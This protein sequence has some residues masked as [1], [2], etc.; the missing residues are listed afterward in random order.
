MNIEELLSRYGILERGHFL[1]SSGLHSEFYF[2]KAKIIQNPPLLEK[3]AGMIKEKFQKEK[4]DLVVGPTTAGAIIAYEVARQIPSRFSYAEK[5]DGRRKIR[6]GFRIN[7]GERALVVDDVLTTGTS[8]S[9][10]LAALKE[11]K[12]AIVGIAV[13]VDRSKGINLP[14]PFFSLYRKEI[15][16]Y[17]PNT[18][19][20]CQKGIPLLIPG[21]GK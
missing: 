3:L 2:E 14:Y 15:P 10:T 19:P 18:C 1:L 17:E 9:E 16:N 12:V 4:V 13:I 21:R 8:I 7:E 6:R 5:D 11:Y 20:L